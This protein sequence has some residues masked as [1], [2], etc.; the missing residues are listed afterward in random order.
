MFFNLEILSV[1]WRRRA[2]TFWFGCFAMLVTSQAVGGRV[3]NLSSK[4]QFTAMQSGVAIVGKF[5]KFVADVDFDPAAPA[6]GKIELLIDVASV[7][8]GSSDADELLKSQEFFNTVHFPQANFS[9]T[10]ISAAGVGHFQAPGQLTLKGRSAAIVVPFTVRAEGAGLRIEGR[11][12]LS[13]LAY[14]V[15]EGQWADTGT[16]D[17]QVQVQFSLYLPR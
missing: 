8:T 7:S 6:V 2:I 9:A 13:R 17:D 11:L 10:S 14:H 15:G 4:I 1:S 5:Q 3:D 12:S 16:L